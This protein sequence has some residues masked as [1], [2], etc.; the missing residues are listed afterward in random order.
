[1][2]RHAGRRDVK[3][4]A[5]KRREAFEDQLTPAIDEPRLLRAVELGASRDVVVVGLVRL[6]EVGGIRVRNRA[7]LS[8]PVERRAGVESAGERDADLL[9]GRERLKNGR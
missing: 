5:L 8:H 3:S 4:A 9:A 7:A 2:V 1:E 6:S